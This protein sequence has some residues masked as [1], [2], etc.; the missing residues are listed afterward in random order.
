MD[1]ELLKLLATKSNKLNSLQELTLVSRFDFSIDAVEHFIKRATFADSSFFIL[2]INA[3]L[4]EVEK[5]VKRII[6]YEVI[7]QRKSR[8]E[9]KKIDEKIFVNMNTSVRS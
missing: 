1:D 8:F 9:L 4:P 2:Q 6:K 7:R 5:M 3:T